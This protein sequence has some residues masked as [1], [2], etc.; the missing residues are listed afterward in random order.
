MTSQLPEG[1]SP[2]HILLD[3]IFEAL[4]DDIEASLYPERPG[5]ETE[6]YIRLRGD[7]W[8]VR[9]EHHKHPDTDKN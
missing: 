9:V 7:C 6:L 1:E 5:Y 3:T 4:P 8:R 2:N